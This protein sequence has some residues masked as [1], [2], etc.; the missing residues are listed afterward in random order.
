MVELVWNLRRHWE[1]W[2]SFYVWNGGVWLGILAHRIPLLFFFE[3]LAGRLAHNGGVLF[4]SE[5][6]IRVSCLARSQRRS[7]H[8]HR[9]LDYSSDRWGA[10]H[11]VVMSNL[12]ALMQRLISTRFA[13]AVLWSFDV[14]LRFKLTMLSK[15]ELGTWQL[16]M[17]NLH[18]KYEH[19]AWN[20]SINLC[21]VL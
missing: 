5:I 9:W 13:P 4:N 21:I 8:K 14:K 20:M 3:L 15:V 7:T 10:V 17:Q 12:S 2:Q 16:L 1:W 6:R 19:L 11:L 18:D